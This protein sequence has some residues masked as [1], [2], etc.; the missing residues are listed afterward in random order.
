MKELSIFIDESG[1]FGKYDSISPYYIISMVFHDQSLSMKDIIE[2]L[3]Y[4]VSNKTGSFLI[5]CGPL[6]RKE[7]IYKHLPYEE[8]RILFNSLYY[9][10]LKSPITFQEIIS[11]KKE[12]ENQ[13]DLYNSLY[14][15]LSIFI[16]DNLSYLT[17]FDIIKIYYDNGQNQLLDLIRSTF[18]SYLF[19]VELK[20]I[21]PDEYKL[22]QV[23]DLF[24]TLTLL[25]LKFDNHNLSKSELKF[26]NGRNSLKKNYFKILKR[27]HF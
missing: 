22:Q 3:T 20:T 9:F 21:I 10:A 11:F 1:D 6:I 4:R 17:S 24:C 2:N 26:F 19:N 14:T 18:Q 23:A 5:H 7:N 27:K 12:Y 8:R 15:K 16:N 13:S 25:K